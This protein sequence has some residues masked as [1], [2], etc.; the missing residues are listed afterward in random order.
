MAG[1]LDVGGDCRGYAAAVAADAA[2]VADD[3]PALT[4]DGEAAAE[5][6][7]AG[8]EDGPRLPR[9]RRRSLRM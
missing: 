1:G 2:V 6:A 3:E 8:I 4:A 7:K 9:M 5:D